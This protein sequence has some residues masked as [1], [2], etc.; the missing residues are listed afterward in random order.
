M[1]H[2]LFKNP[3]QDVFLGLT[4]YEAVMIKCYAQGNNTV[5]MVRLEPAIPEDSSTEPLG[6][7]C[8]HNALCKI[9]QANAI[10]NH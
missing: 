5:P 4:E 6:V 7:C 1:K 8:L 9:L 10:S 3:C 2:G